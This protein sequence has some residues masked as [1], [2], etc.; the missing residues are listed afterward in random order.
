MDENQKKTG[1]ETDPVTPTETPT[2]AQPEDVREAATRES[3][4][5]DQ[6]SSLKSQ[7][8]KDVEGKVSSEV[9]QSII[10]KIGT[11]LGLTKQEEEKLPTDAETL[12]KIVDEQVQAGINQYKTEVEEQESRSIEEREQQINQ[13]I[14]GWH[15]QYDQLSRMGKVPKVENQSDPNDKGIVARRKIIM[16]IG[17]MIEQNKKDGVRYTPTVSDVLLAS[18]NVL[19]APPGADLPISGNTHVR[20]DDSAFTN[21]EIRNKSFAEIARGG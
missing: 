15:S 21:A 20:E 7:I 8:T 2:E 16:A 4:S 1:T 9:S 5:D 6:I 13:V 14:T 11:A 12:K 3:I 19:S 10:A 17:K 18:P